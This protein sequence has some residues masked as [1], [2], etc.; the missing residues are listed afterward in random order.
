MTDY[1]RED[2]QRWG[3]KGGR[4][5]RRT[6]TPEQAHDMAQRSAD[7]RSGRVKPE[8]EKAPHGTQE[9][10]SRN[11]NIQHGC[12]HDCRYCYAKCMAI[13]FG[14]ARPGTWR[15][16]RLDR[17]KVGK[18]YGNRSGT[19]MFP[20]THDITPD[21]LEASVA[22]LRKMLESGNDVLIVSKPH[23]ECVQRICREFQEYK[24]QI[25]FRF[26]IGS[27]DNAVLSYWEPNAPPF[28]ERLQSLKWAYEQGYQTSVS[29]E[30]VL[31]ARID[32]V[33]TAVKPYV[34]DSVWL[35]RAN[36]LGPIISMNCPGDADA[37]AKAE[38]LIAM[39]DDEWVKGLYARY[40]LDRFI[41]WKDSVKEV[42]GLPRPKRK[43]MDV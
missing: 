4:K 6:L 20:T 18:G 3:A 36:R 14:R 30:P 27:A 33:V 17:D 19:I 7:I 8:K 26:T 29:C 16:P 28:R 12:E 23:L 21:N 31:D 24:G 2:F 39:I 9:W 5:S 38:E 13:R 42:V 35:G 37:K 43:G 1:T 40:K 34:T 22:V 41:R 10:A 25:L 11:I 32:R 15:T